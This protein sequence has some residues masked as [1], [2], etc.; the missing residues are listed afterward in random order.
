MEIIIGLCFNLLSLS[1]YL[2]WMPGSVAVFP[3]SLGA[4]WL[5]GGLLNS[6][7][8]TE[9]HPR[10]RSYVRGVKSVGVEV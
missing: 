8:V 9:E 7:P 5:E 3:S 2:S 1:F 4:P 10:G 6:A